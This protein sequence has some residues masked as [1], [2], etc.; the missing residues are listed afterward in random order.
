MVSCT[1]TEQS[2]ESNLKGVKKPESKFRSRVFEI[3]TLV[4]Q[5][6]SGATI[7]TDSLPVH[8][9][10]KQRMRRVTRH[11]LEALMSYFGGDEDVRTSTMLNDQLFV[12]CNTQI[13]NTSY[14]ASESSSW[15]PGGAPAYEDGQIN[16]AQQ[17]GNYG[18]VREEGQ[19]VSIIPCHMPMYRFPAISTQYPLRRLYRASRASLAISRAASPSSSILPTF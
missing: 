13:P 7:P 12:G 14:M 2:L 8:A 17:C 11:G 3:G 6:P 9:K 19:W 15:G 1:W 16:S 10:N 18:A 4:G 5:T